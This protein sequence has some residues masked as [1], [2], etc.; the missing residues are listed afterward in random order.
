M[1]QEASIKQS[2]LFMVHQSKAMTTPEQGWHIYPHREVRSLEKMA[3][4]FP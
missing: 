1:T 4:V 3:G 2:R